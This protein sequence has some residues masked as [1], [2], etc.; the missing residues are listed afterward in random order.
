MNVVKLKSN[1]S[2]APN[3]APATLALHGP[4]PLDPQTSL[5][6]HDN[7]MKPANQNNI[8]TAS[9]ARIPYLCEYLG[10]WMGAMMR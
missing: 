1:H 7:A 5:T 4:Q 10:A 3:T 2:K 9:T 6:M 8:V